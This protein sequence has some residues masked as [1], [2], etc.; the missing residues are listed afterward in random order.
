MQRHT[1]YT[2]EANQQLSHLLPEQ[3]C[4]AAARHYANGFREGYVRFLMT[5]DKRVPLLAPRQYQTV[6]YETVAGQQAID[7]WFNGYEA[8][9]SAAQNSEREAFRSVARRPEPQAE[10]VYPGMNCFSGS[11]M[12][13]SQACPPCGA[14]TFEMP[15]APLS[16]CCPQPGTMHPLDLH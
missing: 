1:V 16:D 4:G 2:L 5:G 10:A 15:P 11:E 6:F 9:L 14:W 7:D 13:L 3:K 8:G 12:N